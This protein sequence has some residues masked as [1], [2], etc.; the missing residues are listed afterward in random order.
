MVNIHLLIYLYFRI[1]FDNSNEE[2]KRNYLNYNEKV[3]IIKIIIDY[4]VK[5]FKDLFGLC[6]FIN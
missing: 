5:T 4:L 2:I 6:N 3:K 1:Y